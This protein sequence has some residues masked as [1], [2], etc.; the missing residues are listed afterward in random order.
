MRKLLR[1]LA[2]VQIGYQLPGRIPHDSATLYRIIQMRDLDDAGGLC[3]EKMAYFIPQRDAERYIVRDGD[4]VFQAR[5]T[6]N[7][8]F[9]LRDVPP[10]TLASNHF[11][12]VRIRPDVVM[13][14]YVAWFVNQ[15]S[16]QAHLTGKA[17]GTTMML[18]PKEAFESLEVEVPPLAVQRTIV[19]IAALR[20]RERGLIEHL[21]RKRD[22]LI[23]TLCLRA[24]QRAE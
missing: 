11:Y 18:V 7:L 6:R 24:A 4:M 15:P 9:V 14:E 12:I 19:E 17:Q 23:R 8:A 1:E 3:V 20:Q 2:A 10:D 22:T 21:E 16:A 5:G 13:P